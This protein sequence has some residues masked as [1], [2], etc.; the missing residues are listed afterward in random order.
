MSDFTNTNKASAPSTPAVAPVTAGLPVQAQNLS[1]TISPIVGPKR[2][3]LAPSHG[4]DYMDSPLEQFPDF[5][6]NFGFSKTEE[7]PSSLSK[8]GEPNRLGA[9]AIIMQR[10]LRPGSLDLDPTFTVPPPSVASGLAGGSQVLVSPSRKTMAG[11][12]FLKDPWT[13]L[14][15]G[16]D[17]DP[18]E[19]VPA[20]EED[21][22]N[23]Q[24]EMSVCIGCSQRS[25]QAS[26]ML[27]SKMLANVSLSS[28]SS[29]SVS[30]HPGLSPAVNAKGGSELGRDDHGT[31]VCEGEEC[32][33]LVRQ[34]HLTTRD[35][36]ISRRQI[37]VCEYKLKQLPE[38]G[39]EGIENWKKKLHEEIHS[40]ETHIGECLSSLETITVKL[41]NPQTPAVVSQA[42][43]SEPVSPIPL[44]QADE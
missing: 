9:A 16:I 30:P 28:R 35:L 15:Q 40:T 31:G 25:Q 19:E 42:G 3:S 8:T 7:D 12:I 13:V 26:L 17:N 41:E 6:E 14:H 21:P 27:A 2:N 24:Y 4:G 1:V 43:N 29:L 34:H 23:D 22:Q 18:T 5:D 20:I 38:N 10:R 44:L 32:A 33:A 39:A 37:E 11:H 36:L